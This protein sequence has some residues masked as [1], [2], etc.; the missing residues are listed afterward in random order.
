MNYEWTAFT[1]LDIESKS[2]G[3][4]KARRSSR[5]HLED[6]MVVQ[7]STYHNITIVK[8]CSAQSLKL[9]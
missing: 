3:F 2:Y 1:V 7:A 6:P 9:V 5:D 8:L 4:S